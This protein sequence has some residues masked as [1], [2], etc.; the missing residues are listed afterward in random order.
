[1]GDEK[2]SKQPNP[3]R[4]LGDGVYA[5]FGGFE[6]MIHIRIDD[7]E[8][9]SKRRFACG[10]G[11]ELP[12]GDVY[13]FD[14]E[15]GLHLVSCPVC[16]PRGVIGV[17]VYVREPTRFIPDCTCIVGPIIAIDTNDVITIKA[18]VGRIGG[19]YDSQLVLHIREVGRRLGTPLSQLSSRPGEPGYDEWLRI[20]RSWGY[21]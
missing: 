13:Y 2:P 18:S 5:E 4:Y 15:S 12:P 3:Q 7:E 17:D 21:D 8:L 19:G 11:P 9:N 14:G 10:I 1:M 6:A 16:N 20:S